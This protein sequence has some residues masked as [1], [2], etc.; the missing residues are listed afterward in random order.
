MQTNFFDQFQ[1]NTF[2][3]EEFFELTPAHR[4]AHTEITFNH[5]LEL[6]NILFDRLHSF[7]PSFCFYIK[8]VSKT[9]RKNSRGKSGKYMLVWKY[10]PVYKRLFLIMR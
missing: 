10:V 5:S 3:N 7:A 8:S 1:V 4:L 6:K 9:L 2:L